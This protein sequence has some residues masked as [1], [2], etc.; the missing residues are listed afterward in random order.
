MKTEKLIA[1]VLTMFVMLCFGMGL[2]E[3]YAGGDSVAGIIFAA[4]AFATFK[5]EQLGRQIFF[6]K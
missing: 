3:I 2:A 4:L 6:G 5:T 1:L